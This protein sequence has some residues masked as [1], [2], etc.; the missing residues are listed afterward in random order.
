MLSHIVDVARARRY[1]R[2]SLETGSGESFGAAVHL[3]ESFGFERCGPFGDYIDNE[4][5][6][7]FTLALDD[8]M[9]QE[10]SDGS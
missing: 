6:R 7:F 8:R 10:G 3:Y 1:S 2:V 5:S 4:F 9:P